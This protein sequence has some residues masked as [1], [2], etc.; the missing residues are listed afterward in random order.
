[1]NTAH[2]LED[3]IR[4]LQFKVQTLESEKQALKACIAGSK[5]AIERAAEELYKY[6]GISR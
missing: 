3:V 2:D 6:K 5:A 1:M 4:D